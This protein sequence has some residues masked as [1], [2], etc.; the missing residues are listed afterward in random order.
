MLTY[1][2]MHNPSGIAAATAYIALMWVALNAECGDARTILAMIGLGVLAAAPED[3]LLKSD[4]A[5]IG[6]FFV[7]SSLKFVSGLDLLWTLAFIVT[8]LMKERL[9]WPLFAIF[10]AAKATTAPHGLIEIAAR[11]T[12]AT[13]YSFP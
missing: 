10:Q 1:D 3:E 12:L 5:F 8:H 2:R 11:S 6:D 4:A 9:G 13:I 7:F